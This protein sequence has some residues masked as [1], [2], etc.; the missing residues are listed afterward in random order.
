M[1]E[2]EQLDLL[3]HLKESLI[4]ASYDVPNGQGD[5]LVCYLKNLYP[6]TKG[7]PI[8]NYWKRQ[9]ITGNFPM[10]GQIALHYLTIPAG[11]TCIKRVFPHSGRL[12]TPTW[13]AL[14]AQTISHLTCLKEWLNDETSPYA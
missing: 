12:R 13:E 10:L 9:I 8:I 5:E 7:E 4:E 1:S 11:S 3:R 14:G 2:S 6:M